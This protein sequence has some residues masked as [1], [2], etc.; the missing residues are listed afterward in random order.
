MLAEAL[1]PQNAPE[2]AERTLHQILPFVT[3]H[4]NDSVQA[5]V[6]CLLGQ[7]TAAEGSAGTA[8]QLGMHPHW[9]ELPWFDC[10][11]PLDALQTQQQRK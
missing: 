7:R 3:S 1:L 2:E 11:Q 4:E 5:H 6:Y 10:V 8:L 9:F